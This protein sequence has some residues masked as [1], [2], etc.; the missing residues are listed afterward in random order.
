VDLLRRRVVS[1]MTVE[2]K[3]TQLEIVED[4]QQ[5]TTNLLVHISFSLITIII[6]HYNFSIIL[7]IV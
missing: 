3:I 6:T 5:M 1:E 2:S 7:H 4:D